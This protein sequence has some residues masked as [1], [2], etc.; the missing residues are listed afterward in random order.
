MDW[1]PRSVGNVLTD[2]KER[3]M[4]RYFF[5]VVDDDGRV[6]DDEGLELPDL[7]AATIECKEIAGELLIATFNSDQE[8]DNRRIEV[9]DC[10]GQ[11][12]KVC[13][14]RDLIH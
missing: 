7:E 9:T 14:L 1:K 13:K 3:T 12:L 6:T 11:V 5:H 4:S 10:G 2:S 8:V